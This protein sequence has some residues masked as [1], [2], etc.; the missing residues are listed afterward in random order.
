MCGQRFFCLLNWS[1]I[2]REGYGFVCLKMLTYLFVENWKT[3]PVYAR[4]Q[5]TRVFQLIYNPE[6]PCKQL[7][8][9]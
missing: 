6:T 4:G 7:R 9:G 5:W 8:Q 2:S 3:L 1:V